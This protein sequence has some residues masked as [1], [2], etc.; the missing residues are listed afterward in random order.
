MAT[1]VTRV[2]GPYTVTDLGY[3]LDHDGLALLDQLGSELLQQSDTA[4]LTGASATLAS[5][6]VSVATVERVS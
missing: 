6:S 2:A 4:T 3:L 5:V 1:T